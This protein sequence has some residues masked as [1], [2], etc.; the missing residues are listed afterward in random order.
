MKK[1]VVIMLAVVVLLGPVWVLLTVAVVMNPAATSTCLTGSRLRVGVIPETLAASTADGLTVEVGRSQLVH[2]AT[3]IAVGSR[4]TG[5]D[6]DAL[7]IALMAALTE[8]GLRMVAN[9]NAYPESASYPHDG[10]GGD[11]DSLGL[12]QMRP[13]AGWGTVAELMDPTYQVRAFFGGSTGP[14]YLSPAGLL[15]VPGWHTLTRGEAAQAV[16]VSAFPDRYANWEPVATTILTTLTT[17]VTGAIHPGESMPLPDTGPVVFA[18][19]QGSWQVSSRFGPR[20]HPVTGE[21]RVH[22]GTDYAVADGTPIMAVADG[23]VVFAGSLGGYGNAIMI[24]H[25][26]DAGEVTSVYGHMWDHHI[27]VGVGDRVVAGQ[28]IADVGSAGHSTGPHLHLEIRLHH[29]DTDLVDPEQWL[30]D[31][32]ATERT[33]TVTGPTGCYTRAW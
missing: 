17:P 20:V 16:E 5:V 3:I 13:Q 12:F 6:R 31:H 1:L 29:D 7:V 8:S 15:D 18:L 25:M 26:I 11:H 23:T 27:Y 14:N 30:A 28:H 2:A 33:G 9:T 10:D 4:T 24:T 22:T 32:H 19:P 21:S